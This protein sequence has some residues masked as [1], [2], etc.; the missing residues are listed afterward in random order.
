M[1]FYIT[2]PS[3]ASMDLFPHNRLT[4]FRTQLPI[5]LKFDIPYEV[6]L[7]E[8]IFIQ[9]WTIDLGKVEYHSENEIY[10]ISVIVNDGDPISLIIDYI[11]KE[12]EN[13]AVEKLKKL[14]TAKGETPDRIFEETEVF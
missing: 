1:S 13:I 7:V 2:L 5:P 10:R 9:S 6:A 8:M 11:N 3:N 12:L 14:L 4:N